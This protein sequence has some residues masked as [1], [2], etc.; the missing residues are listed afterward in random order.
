MSGLAIRAG[1]LAASSLAVACEGAQKQPPPTKV[2]E[3]KAAAPVRTLPWFAGPWEGTFTATTYTISMSDKEGGIEEWKSDAGAATQPGSGTLHLTIDESRSVLGEAS[4]AL[5]ELIISG[6]L[7]G[8]QL[9]LRLRSKP[10]GA[11]AAPAE[12]WG[13]Y[14]LA[15][16]D[17]G[18]FRGHLRAA[19]GNG[20]RVRQGT[21][22]LNSAREDHGTAKPRGSSS[23]PKP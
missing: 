7:D 11:A 14:I 18:S 16:R 15:R 8:E 4:G 3:A 2:S 1:L 10:S 9:R 23:A 6:E 5:G 20:H 21:L 12:Q 19:T 22:T 17:T 13:G